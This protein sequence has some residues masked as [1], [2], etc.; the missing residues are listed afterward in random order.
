MGN[1]MDGGA[2][3]RWG[4]QTKGRRQCGAGVEKAGILIL[5]GL[6]DIQIRWPSGNRTVRDKSLNPDNLAKARD[7][8]WTSPDY[9]WKWKWRQWTKWIR[10]AAG[11]KEAEGLTLRNTCLVDGRT[12]KEIN[13]GDIQ[14]T[15]PGCTI[16]VKRGP[17]GDCPTKT[18][19]VKIQRRLKRPLGSGPL[20]I[21]SD[22]YRMRCMAC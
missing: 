21:H 19:T 5:R 22:L 4:R 11:I 15:T 10:E 9:R 6:W 12:C 13:K 8:V 3:L 1:R 20:E 16:N 2:V 18:D 7:P 14:R 17:A